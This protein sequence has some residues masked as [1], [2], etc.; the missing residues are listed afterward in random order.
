[1]QDLNIAIFLYAVPAIKNELSC[2]I[3]TKDPDESIFSNILNVWPQVDT[4]LFSQLNL[5]DWWQRIDIDWGYCPNHTSRMAT[6]ILAYRF[7]HFNSIWL[8]LHTHTTGDFNHTSAQLNIHSHVGCTW[9]AQSSMMERI[10]LPT[11]KFART[12]KA[13]AFLKYK[14]C[15]R[16]PLTLGV[17]EADWPLKD[18]VSFGRWSCDCTS[19]TWKIGFSRANDIGDHREV[20]QS[21]ITFS[22]VQV[23]PLPK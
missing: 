19:N 11:P 10:F 16:E 13:S 9:D 1:M 6:P 22:R 17:C 2:I 14:T 23:R 8:V 5:S 3:A 18:I 15:T 7:T 21:H 20:K 12:S 4:L